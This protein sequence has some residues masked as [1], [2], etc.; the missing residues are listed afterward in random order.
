MFFAV[1][2]DDRLFFKVDEVNLPSYEEHNAEQWVIEGDPPSPM[3]YREVPSSVREDPEALGSWIDAAVEV[4]LRK[5]K[6]K[7]KKS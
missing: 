4:A 2:D 7:R 5:K 6:P 1:I 3:P